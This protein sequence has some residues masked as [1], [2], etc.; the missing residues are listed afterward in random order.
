MNI[1]AER[2][3]TADIRKPEK[4]GCSPCATDTLFKFSLFILNSQLK[5]EFLF[6]TNIACK[7][8]ISKY[9]LLILNKKN[10]IF[11]ICLLYKYLLYK[12]NSKCIS[13]PGN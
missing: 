1:E 10:K 9:F 2:V 3:E 7:N 5:N 8:H 12:I 4:H 13:K 6:V 11:Y